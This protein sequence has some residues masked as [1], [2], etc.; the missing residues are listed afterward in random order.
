ML[1]VPAEPGWAAAVCLFEQVAEVINI[2]LAE[3]RRNLAYRFFRM[4]QLLRGRAQAKVPQI[5][6]GCVSNFF[7]EMPDQ[8]VPGQSGHRRSLIQRHRSVQIVQKKRDDT[9]KHRRQQRIGM[10]AGKIGPVD[11][12]AYKPFLW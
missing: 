8:S 11:K 5:I 10:V 3:L 9:L 7:P 1:H 4:G 2:I 6:H 12:V